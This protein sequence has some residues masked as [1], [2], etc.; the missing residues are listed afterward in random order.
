MRR[1]DRKLIVLLAGLA[2]AVGGSA[3]L[4]GGAFQGRPPPS[5][6]GLP[7]AS[8]E[9]RAERIATVERELAYLRLLRRQY[10]W[11]IENLQRNIDFIRYRQD[12]LEEETAR[13]F[14]PAPA[15]HPLLA[16]MATELSRL[17]EQHQAFSRAEAQVRARL[18]AL[19][20]DLA[21]REATF[22]S[23]GAAALAGF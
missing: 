17:P 22:A 21:A 23:E 20:A 19:E 6:A 1:T 14:G 16:S 7:D 12:L 3:L 8:A 10:R 11:G 13:V 5:V 15:D 4:A 2:A 18:A 9:E